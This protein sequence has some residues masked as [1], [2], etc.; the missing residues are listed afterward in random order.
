M[1]EAMQSVIEYFETGTGDLWVLLYDLSRD[2]LIK[3]FKELDYA[4]YDE[5]GRDMQREI[6]AK[7]AES[8]KEF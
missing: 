6:Y 2:E 7:T 5:Y 4:V 8:L 3:L 1:S